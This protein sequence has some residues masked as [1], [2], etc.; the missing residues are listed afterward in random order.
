MLDIRIKV[1]QNLN[2]VKDLKMPGKNEAC[3]NLN[4]IQMY[5]ES[6]F[7]LLT[8]MTAS[9]LV[10]TVF[11]S[12]CLCAFAFRKGIFWQGKFVMPCVKSLNFINSKVA[13][14]GNV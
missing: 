12:S 3:S 14:C 5:T 9:L 6:C 10:K 8:Y 7:P 4:V 1:S 2:D 11:H 13:R